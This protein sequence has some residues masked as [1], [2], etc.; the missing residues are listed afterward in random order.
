MSFNNNRGSGFGWSLRWVLWRYKGCQEFFIEHWMDVFPGLRETESICR[1]SFFSDDGEGTMLFVVKFFDGSICQYVGS[2]QPYLITNLILSRLSFLFIVIVFHGFLG[3]N[4]CCFG[5][6]VNFLHLFS[7]FRHRLAL[8][9]L[10]RVHSFIWMMTVVDKEWRESCWCLDLVVVW[11]LSTR[12]PFIPVRLSVVYERTVKD[13]VQLLGWFILSVHL[14]VD[15]TQWTS[16][17]QLQWACEDPSWTVWQIEDHNHWWPFKEVH[18]CSTHGHG[19]CERFPEPWVPCLLGWQW[20]FLRT[21][22]QL[23]GW[24]CSHSTLEVLQ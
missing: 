13:T 23:L 14:F 5:F 24:Y 6:F 4:Q 9:L 17:Q 20:S 12:Q 11:E 3:H 2:F 15:D 21:D 22:Q 7:E 19:R 10:S 1:F 18:A 16:F 8:Y